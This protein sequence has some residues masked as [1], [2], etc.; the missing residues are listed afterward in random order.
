MPLH[1]DTAA[2]IR[3]PTDQAALVQAVL[4]ADRTDETHWLEWKSRLD[5]TAVEGRF[6][7]AKAV[8][9]LANRHPDHAARAM[10]GNG[11]LMIG[12]EPANLVGLPPVDAADLDAQLRRFLGREGP[13]WSPTWIPIDGTHVLLITVEPPRWGDPIY[14]LHR[15]HGHF[16]A[17]T[18]FA[19]RSTSTRPAGPAEMAYLQDRV[20][21][22]ADQF[23]V[24]LTLP[25]PARIQ[26]VD[27]RMGELESWLTAGRRR[28]LAPLEQPAARRHDIPARNVEQAD[29]GRRVDLDRLR[30]LDETPTL[31]LRDVR[32][33]ATRR[34]AGVE[35]SPVEQE[36]LASAEAALSAALKAAK[37]QL[38]GLG[39]GYEPEDR[40]PEAYRAEVDAYVA[41]AK[42]QAFY[43]RMIEAV[44]EGV[45]RLQPSLVNP[46]DRNFTKIQVELV[47]NESI[48]AVDPERLPSEPSLPSPPRQ[49][50]KLRPR[51]W[52]GAGWDPRLLV[53]PI[54]PTVP[55]VPDVVIDRGPPC[56]IQWGIDHL[57]PRG[58][59]TL[60]P[61]F[62]LIPP[63]YAGEVLVAEWTA[64]ARNADGVS[65]G[66]LPIS[67]D[68]TPV[69]I[70]RV[71]EQQQPE[72]NEP[73]N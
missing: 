24:E 54:R 36:R 12:V 57:S 71:I 62:A 60:A 59:E 55:F 51:S 28:L 13:Q 18:V 72:P 63:R 15:D 8:L 2:A 64:T 58:R 3:R 68:A 22:R 10:Q 52:L 32:E 29:G 27:L 73:N 65:S 46:T 16:H 50:G 42:E 70:A 25:G 30:D 69:V 23:R 56:R 33:L 45:G 34:D 21:R 67:I 14:L 19:R 53:P 47:I 66:I 61:V 35:L 6:T 5:L 41:E 7:V 17:G 4:A 26:P 48:W 9:G 39:A 49:W 11:Y 20:R 37:T 40:S 43:Q 38:L 1:I 31:T 44:Q